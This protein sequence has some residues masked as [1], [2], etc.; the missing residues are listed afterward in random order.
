MLERVATQFRLSSS[1][2]LSSDTASRNLRSNTAEAAHRGAF[3]VPR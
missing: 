1:D 2:L 3:G